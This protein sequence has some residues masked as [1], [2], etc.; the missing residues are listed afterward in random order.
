MG[1]AESPEQNSVVERFMRT[2][3]SRLRSQLIHGNIPLKLWGEVIMATSFILNLFPSKSIRYTCPEYAWKTLDLGIETPDVPYKRLK[4]IG[5]LAYTIPPG[6][7][8]KLAPRS[9]K[10]IMI[11][12]EINSNAYRLWD[13]A[14]NRVIVSNDVVFNEQ[15]FPLRSVDKATTEE[16]T[17]LNDEIWDEAWDSTVTNPQATVENIEDTH[18]ESDQP[19]HQTPD[20]AP[21]QT[22]RRSHRDR[23]PVEHFG[24]LIGYHTVSELHQDQPSGDDDGPENDEPS[25]S[26]AMKGANRADWIAAMSDKFSSLQLHNVGK[27]VEPP[28]E[29]KF[30]PGM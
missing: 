2:I 6:H 22:S 7:Q 10:T 9:V 27:L 12:Y 16:L 4:V 11:G 8:N 19:A 24:N 30:L 18:L 5:C 26:R 29:A 28:P 3:A 1:P 17:I 20:P 23:Q 15:S 21:R 25:Y 14:S 13:P